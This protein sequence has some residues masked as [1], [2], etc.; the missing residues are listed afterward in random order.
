LE[1]VVRVANAEG[2]FGAMKSK[3][4]GAE[5]ILNGDGLQKIPRLCAQHWFW[6]DESGAEYY[7]YSKENFSVLL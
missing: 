3:V 2:H 7:T 4:T 6:V 1:A 5:I